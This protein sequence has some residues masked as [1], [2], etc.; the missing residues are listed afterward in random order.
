[1]KTSGFFRLCL[2]FLLL[3]LIC[4]TGCGTAKSIY[5]L[6]AD[7][8]KSVSDTVIPGQK[9]KLSKRVMVVPIIN[10]AG[11]EE[12]KIDEITNTWES[13]LKEY[14]KVIV[15]LMN[16]TEAPEEDK[17]SS[18][19]G[20]TIDQELIKKAEE[21]DMDILITSIMNPFD[22]RIL[23]KGIWPFRK[24]KKEVSVSMTVNVLNIS[25]GALVLF[26]SETRKFNVDDEIVDEED[27]TWEIEN[28][29]L[30]EELSDIMDSHSD[31]IF[32]TL[33]S[34]P[35]TGKLTL[36]EN[37]DLMIN[38]GKD[39]GISEGDVFEVFVKGESIRAVNGKDYY[40]LG[41]KMGEIRAD[42]V[43]QKYSLAVSLNNE[44]YEDGQ[45]VRLKR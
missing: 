10:N 39:I 1:M 19:Y 16:R 12:D 41:Q 34:Q 27:T 43:M 22:V 5:N 40:V 35:W 44:E 31:S 32:D 11:I 24:L 21:M 18:E 13:Y 23:K 8:A 3:S 29:V 9:A 4:I 17:N 30:D 2:P 14:D 6:S 26:K 36:S 7:T 38:G 20:I 37:R 33:D 25:D 42:N 45:M 28:E 15:T